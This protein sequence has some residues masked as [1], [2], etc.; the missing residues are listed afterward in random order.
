MNYRPNIR[1]LSYNTFQKNIVDNL[2]VLVLGKDFLDI[3]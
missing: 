1:T 3:L 2:Y